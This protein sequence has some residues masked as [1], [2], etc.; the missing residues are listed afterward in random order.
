MTDDGRV[1]L[2][3]MQRT[4]LNKIKELP[5]CAINDKI[6]ITGIWID[7]GWDNSKPLLDNLIKVTSPETITRARRKL[8][9]MGLITYD[10]ATLHKR[11]K[12]FLRVRD[13]R[14]NI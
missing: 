14:G 7:E 8:H 11:Y 3:K 10:K 12:E 4:V 13:N 2:T 9:E 1:R 5:A 6:L